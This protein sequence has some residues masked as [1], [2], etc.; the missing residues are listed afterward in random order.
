MSINENGEV[1]VNTG[2]SIERDHS[3]P[4]DIVYA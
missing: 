4:A 1:V 3:H 2:I